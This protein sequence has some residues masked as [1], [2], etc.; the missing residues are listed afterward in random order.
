MTLSSPSPTGIPHKA[1]VPFFFLFHARSPQTDPTPARTIRLPHWQRRFSLGFVY[2]SFTSF[3]YLGTHN[4][5][6]LGSVYLSFTSSYDALQLVSNSAM[7]EE[8]EGSIDS[9]GGGCGMD[10]QRRWCSSTKLR[11]DRSSISGTFSCIL[12]NNLPRPYAF[13]KGSP[14]FLVDTCSTKDLYTTSLVLFFVYK[15]NSKKDAIR[16]YIY[17]KEN[18]F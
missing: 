14:V 18:F 2:P 15:K 7:R 17:L 1:F 8:C 5:L 3:S 11:Y 4:N 9:M 10:A 6:P 12:R 16:H 13:S